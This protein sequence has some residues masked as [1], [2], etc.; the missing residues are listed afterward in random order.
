MRDM[1]KAE[2]KRVLGRLLS[3]ASRL[4][5]ADCPETDRLLDK[6]RLP[7]PALCSDSAQK[8]AKLS[9]QSLFFRIAPILD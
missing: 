3:D 2:H 4:V 7:F 5:G 6:I 9:S 1:V 8:R